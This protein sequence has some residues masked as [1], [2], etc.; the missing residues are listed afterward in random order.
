MKKKSRKFKLLNKPKKPIRKNNVTYTREIYDGV[1]LNEIK[2]WAE[3]LDAKLEDVSIETKWGYY[4]SVELYAVLSIQESINDFNDR[5]KSYQKS[6]KKYND[7]YNKNKDKIIEEQARR[8]KE[9]K[10]KEEKRQAQELKRKEKEKILIEKEIKQ[11]NK[12]LK[13]L[14]GNK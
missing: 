5:V 14:N 8:E 11:L 12:K 6:L 3:S 2:S 10:K 4:D 7:W 9:E 1:Y 13:S